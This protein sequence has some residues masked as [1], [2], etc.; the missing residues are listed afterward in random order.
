VCVLPTF[1]RGAVERAVR[2]ALLPGRLQDGS[3]GFFDPDRL[4]FGSDVHASAIVGLVQ[5]VPGV[6]SVIITTFER[7]F[8]G[9][10]GELETGELALGALEIA[11]LDP[12]ARPAR[13]RLRL[14][15][16]GGR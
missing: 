11:E 9:P 8:E 1:E 2:S 13:G 15:M 5:A 4:T 14:D 3:L 16:R 10:A 7:R 6:E 12:A